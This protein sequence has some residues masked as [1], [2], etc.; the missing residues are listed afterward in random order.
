V[1]I[2]TR[3]TS[4]EVAVIPVAEFMAALGLTREPLMVSVDF[5]ARTVE[6]TLDGP[7][8]PVVRIVPAVHAPGFCFETGTSGYRLIPF[9][10]RRTYPTA[11]DARRV[12][13]NWLGH[14]VRV[15]G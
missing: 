15:E 12:A 2:E 11:E 1:E 5:R 10:L 3:Q 4:R 8:R 9:D 7:P 14:V 13:S 6:V